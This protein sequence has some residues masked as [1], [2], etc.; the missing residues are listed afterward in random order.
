M[1][2]SILL[3]NQKKRLEQPLW[4]LICF[5][6]FSFWQMGF[7]YFLGPSLTIDGRTPLPIDMDN[8][9]MLIALAYVCSIV[10]M[11]FLP[12]FVVWAQRILTLI[13]L[14]TMIGLFFPL[15]SETLLLLIH[16]HLFCC[17]FM[18][19]F[20]TFLIAN[21]FTENAAIRHLTIAYGVATILISAVQNDFSLITFPVF[22]VIIVIALVLLS[23]FFFRVPAGKAACPRFVKKKDKLIA[24]KRLLI[25]TYIIVF[26]AALMGVS[27]PS[28]VDNIQH[29]VFIIYLTDSIVAFIIYA[30]YKTTKFHPFHSISVCVGIGCI[31]FLLMYASS[32]VPA[33]TYI[34]CVFIGFGV[35]S[36]QILPLYGLVITKTYPTRF[37]A[38]TIIFLALLAV[39]V[40]GSMVEIFRNSLE[41][42][43]LTYGIIMVALVIFYLQLEPYLLYT[44]RRRVSEEAVPYQVPENIVD[45]EA[46]S[47]SVHFDIS[48]SFENGPLSLLSN[49]ELEVV[50]LIGSGYSSADIAKIL[51]I[52]PH[53]VNDHVKNIYRK[54]DV[55]SRLELATLVNRIRSNGNQ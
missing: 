18:I 22:R 7:I 6:M 29:G 36:C 14:A 30:L 34:A 4:M 40:Q 39:L 43:Y 13:S 35:F 37:L 12:H 1:S 5:A 52:S 21:Y 23:I 9:T 50:D 2:Y 51:V 24:P 28:V 15:G 25:G 19:G 17:C 38:P 44:F 26:I 45:V 42:L 31:G 11:I 27:A 3:E 49:R 47:A 46:E 32:Y 20:E 10:W 53:T 54:L 48:K 8:A 55:H 41:L 16:I 33:L